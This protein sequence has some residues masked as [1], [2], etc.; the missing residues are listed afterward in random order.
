MAWYCRHPDEPTPCHLYKRPAE[1]ATAAHC[2]FDAKHRACHA[3]GEQ[4]PCEAVADRGECGG[5]ADCAWSAPLG[6]CVS[7][8]EQV[9]CEHMTVQSAC[10]DTKECQ[11]HG[12][13]GLCRAAAD[14]SPVPC[15][16]Y[17]RED[18]CNAAPGCEFDPGVLFCRTKG[19]R[20]SCLALHDTAHCEAEEHCTWSL[21]ASLCHERGQPVQCFMYFTRN[22]CEVA[23]CEFYGTLCHERGSRVPCKQCTQAP[24]CYANG[25]H[26]DLRKGTCG[27]LTRLQEQ[28]RLMSSH[29]G[30]HRLDC[31]GVVCAAPA[32]SCPAGQ[33][34]Q[35]P[36]LRC[37]AECA[38]TLDVCLVLASEDE[39]TE[40]KC[41]WQHHLQ[42][43]TQI[44]GT[45]PCHLYPGERECRGDA[46][47]MYDLHDSRCLERAEA[48]P[49]CP[50]FD[51]QELGCK[52]L[53]HCTWSPH[54]GKCLSD[55]TH[56]DCTKLPS[57]GL[58]LSQPVECVWNDHARHCT[59]AG[60][61]MEEERTGVR[62][63]C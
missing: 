19:E 45:A 49:P 38:P 30:Q 41:L 40:A 33:V 25:C 17:M 47:C 58:C 63:K 43:C 8:D 31:T 46:T 15:W 24:Q 35:T 32:D 34:L 28:M 60:E 54:M 16:R 20:R 53:L 18:A 23:G 39:C 26:W 7:A 42:T 57:E 48:H 13:A 3:A 4:A 14:E 6:L 55:A 56:I 51:G 2:V 36:L 27:A 29:P 52:Q 1:C 44:D 11:W 22:A 21:S 50:H 62:E 12:A 37:C 5:R 61:T 9:R 10:E 59:F